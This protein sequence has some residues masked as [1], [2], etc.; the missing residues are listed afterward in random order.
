MP[1]SV[2]DV[3]VI[4]AGPIGLYASYLAKEKGL[5]VKI[6]EA[7]NEVGGQPLTLFPNKHIHDYPSYSEVLSS[8]LVDKLY[9]AN[10]ALN[11]KVDK[12]EELLEF[13]K[14][15][16][17]FRCKTSKQEFESKSIILALGNG[18]FTPNKLEII[19]GDNVNVTYKVS[20]NYHNYDN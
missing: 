5:S 7:T 8:D 3:L 14:N 4:G 6:I 16:N 12:S 19:G 2:Y 15:N 17:I 9:N 13:N 18:F 10:K 1:K 11:V 20:K